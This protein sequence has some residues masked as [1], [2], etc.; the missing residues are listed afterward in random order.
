MS[1]LVTNIAKAALATLGCVSIVA[2]TAYVLSGGKGKSVVTEVKNK[3]EKIGDFD[4]CLV[5]IEGNSP[6]VEDDDDD[7]GLSN[8]R[9]LACQ[10]SSGSERANFYLWKKPKGGSEELP[11][12][13][14][15]AQIQSGIPVPLI[16]TFS[17]SSGSSN[18]ETVNLSQSDWNDTLKQ[19]VNLKETCSVSFESKQMTCAEYTKNSLILLKDMERAVKFD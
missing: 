10:S 7:D 12:E 1:F 13:V 8:R 4:D 2:P 15:L 3:F 9:V 16:L 6:T 17:T 11:K 18:T 5:V 19:E 14:S